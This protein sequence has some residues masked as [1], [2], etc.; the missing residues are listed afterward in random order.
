MFVCISAH[1]ASEGFHL[2]RKLFPCSKSKHSP[3]CTARR[4]RAR[5]LET[6]WSNAVTP[7]LLQGSSIWC[8]FKGFQ[9]ISCCAYTFVPQFIP[10]SVCDR[11]LDSRD[12]WNVFNP[13]TFDEK[14]GFC[15]KLTLRG[16]E[17]NG[18]HQNC[19]IH[20]KKDRNQNIYCKEKGGRRVLN[21]N[22]A[23]FIM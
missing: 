2:L 13:N 7:L 3:A 8:P 18:L 22:F 1:S 14:W 16:I 10:I 19:P 11:S 21:G 17:I 12:G 4:T 5:W 6:P 20:Q 23:V 15:Q 9:E